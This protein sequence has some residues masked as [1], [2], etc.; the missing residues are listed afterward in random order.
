MII[1]T[2][3][4]ITEIARIEKL[5]E[6]GGF[7]ERF[8]TEKENGYFAKRKFAPQTVAGVYAA[9]EAFSK[10]LGTGVRG[11][12]LKDV[13]VLYT[14]LGKPYIVLTGEAKKIA[15][16]CAIKKLFVSISHSDLYAVSSVIAEG[17]D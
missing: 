4:D 1:G 17:D 9:K 12:N 15:E 8:F 16:R 2:G 13:E 14:E 11:F 10:A 6:K 5:L 3:I 7:T